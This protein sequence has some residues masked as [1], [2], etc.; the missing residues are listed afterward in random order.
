MPLNRVTGLVAYYQLKQKINHGNAADQ[1]HATSWFFCDLFITAD[2]GF[3]E[4]IS[5]LVA[6]QHYPGHA[7]PVFVDRA[8]SS[9]ASQLDAL[10]K[11]R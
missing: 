4:A 8:A 11:D 7:L 5:R 9:F 6:E 3:Y 2:S 1:I 10:L